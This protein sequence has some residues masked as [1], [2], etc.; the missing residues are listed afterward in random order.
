M[1]TYEDW[2]SSKVSVVTR[3]AQRFRLNFSNWLV[4]GILGA[5]QFKLAQANLRFASSEKPQNA[6]LILARFTFFKLAC[7]KTT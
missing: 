2:K 1:V 5:S 6:N 4:E 7:H 3:L